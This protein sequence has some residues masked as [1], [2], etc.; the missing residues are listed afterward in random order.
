VH[1]VGQSN[2]QC[3]HDVLLNKVKNSAG[4][5]ALTFNS[6]DRLKSFTLWVVMNW[7]TDATVVWQFGTMVL[8]KN[9]LLLNV[10][11]ILKFLTK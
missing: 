6:W 11:L 1:R 7:L 4:V 10:I 2:G 3:G 5:M 9:I 8:H